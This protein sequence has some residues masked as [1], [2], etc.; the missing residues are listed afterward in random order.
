MKMIEKGAI[1]K[2]SLTPD[3]AKE[4][5]ETNYKKLPEKK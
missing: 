4:Y 3:K 5:T 2:P 1:V